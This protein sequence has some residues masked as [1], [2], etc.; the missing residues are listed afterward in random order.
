MK[1][2]DWKGRLC[3]TCPTG[4]GEQLKNEKQET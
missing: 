3:V 4:K 2:K 1:A